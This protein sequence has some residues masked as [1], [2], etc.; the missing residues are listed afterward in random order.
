MN[1]TTMV[2][3]IVVLIILALPVIPGPYSVPHFWVTLLN[4]IG[5][6]SIVALGLVLLT[7]VAGLTSFGQA[8]FVGIGA[9]STAYLSTAAGFSP[10]LGF[11][12]GLVL[13]TIVAFVIGAITMRLSGH[14]LPLGTI[15]WGIALYYLYGNTEALGKFDG[16]GGLPDLNLFG[17]LIDTS[18]EIYALIW[19]IL[20]ISLVAISNL[21][22]SR[23]GRA[24]RAL[25]GGAL[26][27]ESM[28][29]NTSWKKV[30]IFVIAADLA[31]ISGFL[32]AHMQRAVNPTP[33]SLSYGIEYLFMAVVGGA[34]SVL[35]AVLGAAS[36]T[37]LK[38]FLQRTLPWVFGDDAN[39][40]AIVFGILMILLLH[41]ARDGLWP[42][43]RK[44]IPVASMRSPSHSAAHA[45]TRSSKFSMNG[46]LL[47]VSKLTKKFGG[48]V[49][50][51]S[52]S[53][54]A[55]NNEIVS[56][57]GPNGAGKSTTFNLI[58]GV[59]KA[60]SGEVWF[61]GKRI[62]SLEMRDVIKLG[63]ARTFQHVRLVR[64]MSVLENVAIGAHIRGTAGFWRSALRLNQDEESAIYAEAE[65]QLRRVGLGDYLHVNAGSLA[66]GQ[67]RILEIA[68]ALCADPSLLLLDEPAAGLREHEKKALGELLLELKREGLTILLVEHDMQF[69]M[70]L[71]DRLVVM[72]FGTKICEGEPQVVVSDTTVIDAYLGAE[73]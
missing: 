29:V 40:E 56:L 33:F 66:L 14:F 27:A 51:N 68:R 48:L 9:Y 47:Q 39:Y 4:Y 35:G 53:F 30:A 57:I 25:K 67:Q 10:W 59:L 34:T 44:L 15:A 58:T 62:D 28:G 70:S 46:P 31:C 42:L 26:M 36:L 19:T 18:R 41:Y 13:T 22:N 32:Y 21:L 65:R 73:V 54:S 16:I 37:M 64:E 72:N 60:T 50:V 61:A 6:Y 43:M 20:V 55:A 17:I 3:L 8:A 38:D 2:F 7:G 5:L 49:A 69:V 12:V 11:L 52:I 1:K 23:K 45:L 71:S 63:I 24:I